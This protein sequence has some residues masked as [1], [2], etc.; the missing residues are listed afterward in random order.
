MASDD[1]IKT[2]LNQ[3]AEW[4][5]QR[6]SGGVG[7][8]RECSYTR[9]QARSGSAGF[10]SPDI[11]VD[12]MEIESAVNELP[13][14]FRTVVRVFYIAPG[15]VEQKARDLGCHRTRVYSRIETAHAMILGLVESRKRKKA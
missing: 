11:D 10:T 5:L 12:A 13:E 6:D 7:F 8:P 1:Y 4:S 14:P 2:R 9:M 15:T 3:W